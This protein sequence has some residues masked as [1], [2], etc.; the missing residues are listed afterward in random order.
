MDPTAKPKLEEATLEFHQKWHFED[1]FPNFP[2]WDMYPFPGGYTK[3]DM[4]LIFWNYFMK[5][6]IIHQK[7]EWDLSNGPLSEALEIL[8][9]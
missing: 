2:R 1:E 6:E 3:S 4:M 9:T 5:H 8:D 7:F